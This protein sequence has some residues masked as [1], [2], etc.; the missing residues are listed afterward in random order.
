MPLRRCGVK[1]TKMEQVGLWVVL[2]IA[3]LGLLYAGML[4]GQVKKADQGTPR[5]Q[6]IAAAVREGADAYLSAQFR[7]I[8][9]LIIIITA[10]LY[11]HLYRQEYTR[12]ALAGRLRSWSARSLVSACGFVGMRLATIGNLRVAAAA[13][14]SFGE[15]MQLGLSH[16]H[17]HRHADRR[18]GTAGRH[19]DLPDLRRTCL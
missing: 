16:R 3:V 7:K 19:D 2:I 17:D 9:I 18:P 8:A 15:A 12:L 4:V 10:G 6:E 14:K 1:Y 5:M 13:R 11:F